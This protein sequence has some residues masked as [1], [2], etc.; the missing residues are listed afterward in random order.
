MS[1]MYETLTDTFCLHRSMATKTYIP[2]IIS[3][4][5]EVEGLVKKILTRVHGYLLSNLPV[6]GEFIR[7]V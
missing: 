5:D 7:E 6:D 1:S 4:K 2:T 3:E